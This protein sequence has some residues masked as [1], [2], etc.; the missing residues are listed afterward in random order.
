[1]VA[2]TT[3]TAG[4]AAI[5][6]ASGTAAAGT[7][8]GVAAT[9]GA[10]ATSASAIT[11]AGAG[12]SIA[13]GTGTA[14][15]AAG[16]TAMTGAAGTAATAGFGSWLHSALFGTA[17]SGSSSAGVGAGTAGASVGATAGTGGATGAGTVATSGLIGSGGEFSTKSLIANAMTGA[18]AASA[19]MS[20]ISMGHQMKAAEK[21]AK[22]QYGQEKLKATQKSNLIR[23]T[24]LKD[25]ASAT[26]AYSSRGVL[27]NTGSPTQVMNEGVNQANQDIGVAQT[28]A[29]LSG[30]QLKAQGKQYG[31][32]APFSLLSGVGNAANIVGQRIIS[33]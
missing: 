7:T 20:G 19:V 4:T 15:G 30:L 2:T 25:V 29:K 11:A 13:A 21:Q 22:I 32:S 14:A 31:R 17:A 9:T 28:D 12:S 3:A 23:E 24:M 33:K 5:G 1:M 6:A 8:A 26:A 18:S 16:T 27:S 10:A